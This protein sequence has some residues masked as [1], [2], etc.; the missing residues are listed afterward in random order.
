[1]TGTLAQ[2]ITLASYGNDFL[3]SKQLLRDFY[4]AN[5]TF[6]FCNVVDFRD[7]KKSLFSKVREIVIA[8]DPNEWFN[9]LRL[10]NCKKIR[11][12]YRHSKDQTLAPDHK[13][14]GMVG[15]GGTWL[16]ETIYNDHSNY[17]SDRWEVTKKDDPDNKI[18]SV[19]YVLTHKKQPISD[20]YVDLQKTYDLLERELEEIGDFAFE[21]RLHDWSDIFRK[22]LNILRHDSPGA[23]YYHKDLII[24]KNYSLLARQILFAAGSAWVFGGMGSWNDLGFDT[25]EENERY[26]ELSARLYDTINQS[27]LAAVNSY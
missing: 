15:G 11:L 17:W 22:A 7:F 2:I 18:W 3:R 13:L 5:S 20:L 25:K 10:S 26:E 19:G 27:I 9:Y 12:Y 6:Q 24:E 8:K 16:L 4:P 21:K 23:E 1:M 14:A